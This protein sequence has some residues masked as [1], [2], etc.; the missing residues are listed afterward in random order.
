VVERAGDV[1][2]LERDVVHRRAALREETAY[3][4]VVREWRDQLDAPVADAQIDGVD[5]LVV[6]SAACLDLGPEEPRVRL[7]GLAEILD[8]HR[9]VMYAADVHRGRSYPLASRRRGASG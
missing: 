6:H 2:D 1:V 8:G 7:D 4:S 5:A 9:H 3:G